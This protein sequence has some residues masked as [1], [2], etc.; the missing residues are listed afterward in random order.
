MKHKTALLIIDVQNDFCPGGSL[1][2]P[3]GDM[4]IPVINK[5]LPEFDLVIFTKDW[6]P[7]DHISFNTR[8]LSDN[9]DKEFFGFWPEHCVENTPGA[10][11]HPDINFKN[12]KSDFYIFKKGMDRDIDS[13]SGFY[14]NDHKKSTGLGEF[15]K[16]R[17]IT[18]V[19]VC[20]LTLDLCV[21]YTAIDSANLGFKTAVIEDACKP[22]D[23]NINEVLVA[24]NEAGISF[25]ESWEL[26][27]FN[28]M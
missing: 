12:I 5:L 26:E 24:F 10:D 16:E 23:Q 2:V 25:I 18:D 6:H 4:I 27:M 11:L 17:E 19:F 14:D 1:A 15:L 13:Y 9:I 28:L 20:G 3:E 21:K 22:I 8:L 7:A